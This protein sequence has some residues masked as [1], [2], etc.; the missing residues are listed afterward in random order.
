[1]EGQATY[2]ELASTVLVPGLGASSWRDQ[3][4]ADSNRRDRTKFTAT[5]VEETAAHM[6]NCDR[7]GTCDGFRY[8]AGSLAHELLVNSYG[9]DT[10]INWNI[11]MAKELPDFRWY[12]MSE[13]VRQ[14]GSAQFASLFERYFDIDLTTWE[15]TEL[16]AYVLDTFS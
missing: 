1:M 11:A 9:V 2:F 10:Y 13:S 16:A 15:Q 6:S 12:G 8:F 3:I 7:S 5:T 4:Q 14:Q